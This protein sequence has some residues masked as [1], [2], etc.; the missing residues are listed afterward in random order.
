[1]RHFISHIFSISLSLSLSCSRT[2]PCS[3]VL[4]SLVRTN[5]TSSYK[6]HNVLRSETMAIYAEWKREQQ[7]KN[8]YE[9]IFIAF[10]CWIWFES[11]AFAMSSC[12][13]GAD[14]SFAPKMSK[15]ICRKKNSLYHQH[16]YDFFLC[17]S[18]CVIFISLLLWFT[19]RFVLALKCFVRNGFS[20]RKK[21]VSTGR[22]QW[23]EMASDK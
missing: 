3:F 17:D 11:S 15:I 7:K 20:Q 6:P 14:S 5:K 18:I 10:D 2:H 21:K 19:F 12:V 4:N 23:V 13:G 16:C 9:D 1:M 8:T 22:A